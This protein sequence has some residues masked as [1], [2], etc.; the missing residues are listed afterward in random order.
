MPRVH[1]K[2]GGE[3]QIWKDSYRNA[4]GGRLLELEVPKK[5][6]KDGVI[7]GVVQ[8]NDEASG[9]VKIDGEVITTAKDNGVRCEN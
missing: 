7:P 5:T 4:A 6:H 3:I 1:E 2:E 9:N 8:F